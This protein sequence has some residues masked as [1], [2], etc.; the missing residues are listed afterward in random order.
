[1]LPLRVLLLA[2]SSL[3]LVAC[4]EPQDQVQS[5]RCDEGATHCVDGETI[6]FCF[7][8]FWQEP[9][10]CLPELAGTPPIQVEIITYCADGGCRPAG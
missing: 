3:T 4:V 6:Q 5:G 9:E 10:A 1:M 8:E 2:L 7:G